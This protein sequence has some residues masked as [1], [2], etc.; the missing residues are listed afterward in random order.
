M[1]EHT[2]VILAYKE[3][4][5]LKPC[6]ESLKAQSEP[7]TIILSTS[8]PSPFLE[9]ICRDYSIPMRINEGESGIAGDWNFAYQLASTK[10]V[11][12]A[13]QDDIYEPTY[14]EEL[15]ACARERHDTLFV[16][17]DSYEI[18][19][20]R[21]T[22]VTPNLF[23]KRVLRTISFL[24][25]RHVLSTFRKRLLFALGN[26]I[27]CPSVMFNASFVREFRFLN[28]YSINLDWDAWYR[29]TSLSGSIACVPRN[30]LGHRLHAQSETTAG[31]GDSRRLNEDRDM[32]ARIWP[33]LVAR[34]LA[35][36]YELGY[37]GNASQ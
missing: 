16:F 6:I 10:Y 9:E 31:I 26:P 12:L 32:F 19:R 4:E 11:T 1:G 35:R 23:V 30:L 5:F 21:R 13:H 8:T 15:L 28:D 27:P 17:C 22:D 3:S 25:Q 14:T 36:V 2:F 7:S 33:A 29:M 20:G 34:F 37:R 18:I 24:H